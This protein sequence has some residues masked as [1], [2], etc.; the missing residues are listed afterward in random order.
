MFSIFNVC[1]LP[2]NDKLFDNKI[3]KI[4]N[5]I[6]GCLINYNSILNSA[7]FFNS[8]NNFQAKYFDIFSND[9]ND[10]FEENYVK[11]FNIECN[12]ILINYNTIATLFRL[13]LSEVIKIVS[14]LNLQ[15]IK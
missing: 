4:Y 10:I 6:N 13:M 12:N 11:M 5:Y 14:Y 7:N 8:K 9:N 3:F 15:Q 1:P 2:I